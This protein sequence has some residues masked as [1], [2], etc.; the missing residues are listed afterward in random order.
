M[1]S[2]MTKGNLP[3]KP[4]TMA[5]LSKLTALYSKMSTAAKYSFLAM[6]MLKYSDNYW[7]IINYLGENYERSVP[8]A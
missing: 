7:E 4:L 1:K 8:R 3:E 2:H 6:I 5:E